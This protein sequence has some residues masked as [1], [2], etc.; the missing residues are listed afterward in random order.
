MTIATDKNAIAEIA[1]LLFAPRAA[2]GRYVALPGDPSPEAMGRVLR[3]GA[4][5]NLFDIT[6]LGQLVWRDRLSER[7]ITARRAILARFGAIDNPRVLH[8]D[9][10]AM[11][12]EVARERQARTLQQEERKVERERR[13]G[14]ERQARTK[15]K[16]EAREKSVSERGEKIQGI[17]KFAEAELK[18]AVGVLDVAIQEAA[19]SAPGIE[20]KLVE[21]A[22]GADTMSEAELEDVQQFAEA[23]EEQQRLVFMASEQSLK[24]Q[25]AEQKQEDEAAAPSLPLAS[26]TDTAI[27]EERDFPEQVEA[28]AVED[29]QEAA[30]IS[31][32]EAVVEVAIDIAESEE[33]SK[34]PEIDQ[35]EVLVPEVL[36][37]DVLNEGESSEG[38]S[39]FVPLSAEVLG[40]FML[41]GV[42]PPS[43]EAKEKLAADLRASQA[44][45][46]ER[47]SAINPII[48]RLRFVGRLQS[49]GLS[50]DPQLPVPVSADSADVVRAA[51]ILADELKVGISSATASTLESMGIFLGVVSIET[52]RAMWAVI[53]DDPLAIS[54]TRMLTE[55]LKVL[56]GR[57]VWGASYSSNRRENDAAID[58]FTQRGVLLNIEGAQR[59]RIMRFLSLVIPRPPDVSDSDFDTALR[60]IQLVKPSDG[61]S[62]ISR[63]A[64]ST[65]VYQTLLRIYESVGIGVPRGPLVNPAEVKEREVKEE[66]EPGL[67]TPPLRQRTQLGLT[68][69][70]DAQGRLVFR[71]VQPAQPVQPVQPAQP[72]QP[73]AA[74]EKE[75]SANLA[76]RLA[77]AISAGALGALSTPA[78]VAKGVSDIVDD[79]P[80]IAAVARDV[81]AANAAAGG[82]AAGLAARAADAARVIVGGIGGL[83]TMVNAGIVAA[84][85][86]GYITYRM[87]PGSEIPDTPTEQEV[88]EA[89][90][91]VESGKRGST[92]E[93]FKSEEIPVPEDFVDTAQIGPPESWLRPEFQSMG[94][95]VLNSQFALTPMDFEN[96]EFSDF[97]Y[98]P[99]VDTQNAIEIDNLFNE[100]LRFSGD[101][102][103]PRYMRDAPPPTQATLN[104][105]A[106]R[107]TDQYQLSQSFAS[108]FESAFTPYDGL[109]TTFNNSVFASDWDKNVLYHD[110][111]YSR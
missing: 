15:T 44:L 35:T 94:I 98:V 69:G 3:I 10:L 5:N 20:Q 100:F 57:I 91:I 106:S 75:A 18:Q 86:I 88:K 52:A 23:V 108:K 76:S 14:A 30:D 92:T 55:S 102:F 80:A 93:F 59:S 90:K 74:D 64:G 77:A 1:A 89:E 105:T 103:K 2:R 95:D 8:A 9:F 71:P 73:I 53:T 82:G 70:R 56:I 72:V 19:E 39:A 41:A 12:T 81:A 61:A 13:R 26:A 46:E 97:N 24:S 85:L 34:A 48:E 40:S 50:A 78:Q 87:L 29:K 101:L 96:R 109:S 36:V 37:P 49:D 21:L 42:L 58:A 47:L 104:M 27:P 111:L 11:R 79:V 60:L 51:E 99:P 67:P 28:D 68:R 16:T 31:P 45:V 4:E 107:F 62:V 22:E 66:R 25:E 17:I 84:L 65:G 38:L 110:N 43:E 32:Q 83:A 7:N 6:E 33:E 54:G 63:R